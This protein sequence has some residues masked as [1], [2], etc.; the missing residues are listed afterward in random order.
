MYLYQIYTLIPEKCLCIIYE[1]CCW[2]VG[3]V[4][5]LLFASSYCWKIN[6]LLKQ[7]D[8]HLAAVTGRTDSKTHICSA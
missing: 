6:G 2:N 7:I 8:H 1:Y 4:I 3:N 5:A